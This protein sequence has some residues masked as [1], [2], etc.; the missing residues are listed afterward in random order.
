MPAPFPKVVLIPVLVGLLTLYAVMLVFATRSI[1]SA[2][3]DAMQRWHLSP[4]DPQLTAEL[5]RVC[6]HI[7]AGTPLNVTMTEREASSAPARPD[8][9]VAPPP[10]RAFRG[11]AVTEADIAAYNASM[12]LNCADFQSPALRYVDA[13]PF[14][15]GFSK[16][17]WRAT[18]NGRSLV[19]KRPATLTSDTKSADAL[20]RDFA[21]AVKQELK[22]FMYLG[23]HPNVIEYY[24]S[25]IANLSGSGGETA[26]AVEGPLVA[27]HAVVS[28]RQLGWSARL[29]LAL[30]LLQL[31]ELL[32][33]SRLV[34]CDWKADQI[35]VTLDLRVKLV[36]LKSLRYHGSAA[37]MSQKVCASDGDCSGDCFKWLFQNNFDVPHLRCDVERGRCRGLDA[38]S[39]LHASAQIAFG[40]LLDK[41]RADAPAQRAPAFARQVELLL[42]NML[43]DA[44]NATS[45]RRLVERV[46]AEFDA[47]ADFAAR[48]LESERIVRQAGL[49]FWNTADTRCTANRFC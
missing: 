46:Y 32:A 20:R 8:A 16:A 38:S 7:A 1:S 48:R 2:C 31:L 33:S 47:A 35:A 42:S 45:V 11:A 15:R 39:M 26:L 34:H 43:L 21:F 44:Q 24:G 12:P 28:S 18:W 6:H 19:V 23:R 4:H 22:F 10:L 41:Y 40:P 14:A 9:P 29:H 30:Q 17:A 37:W 3:V 13:V 49:A 5:H 27:W 25:C 36:D